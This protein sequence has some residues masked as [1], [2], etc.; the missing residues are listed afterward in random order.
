MMVFLRK[1]TRKQRRQ[2]N[3]ILISLGVGLLFTL[4]AIF[5]RPFVSFEWRLEDMLFL[6]T[7]PSSNIVI[8]AIDDESL[9]EHGRWSEWPRSLHAQAINNLAEAGAMV[10]GY[11][12]LFADESSDDP[13]LAQ[14][15]ADA[16]NVV[17]AV[18]GD[19]PVSS[20][21]EVTFQN[22][23]L[24]TSTLEDASAAEGHGNV[25]PDGDG[26]MRRIP[27]VIKDAE[28][29]SYPAL[30]VA[31]LY[32]HFSKTLPSDY[33]TQ[34]GVI[35]LLDRNIPVDSTS[36][37]RI[38]YVGAPGS[39]SQLSY[40]DVIEGNFNPELVKFKIVLV[41]M[42]ATGEPDSW[43]TPISAEKMYG[44][45]I[46]ANAMDTI[47]RQRFMMEG[48]WAI[49]LVTLL[50]FVG[51]T[52]VALPRLNL[53]WG[54]LLTGLIFFGYLVGVFLAFDNG[55]ILS[56]LYPLLVLPLLYVTVVLC[57]VVAEQS[58]RSQIRDLF[59]RYVSPQVAGKIMNLADSDELKLGGE[60]R[61]VTVLFADIRGF[62]TLSEKMVPQSIVTMLNTYLSVIIE[63]VLA[64]DGMVN[65]FA[66][67]SIMAVWN[68]PQD[69]PYHALLAVKAALE[70]EGEIEEMQ[71]RDAS[72]PRV[73]FGIGI[74]SG[75]SIAGNMGSEGR[76]EYTVIGD[77]VNIASRLCSGAPGGRIWI[78]PKTYEEVKDH[79]EVREIEP[80][81]FK[82]K[83]ERIPV[84]Q[85]VRLLPTHV[86]T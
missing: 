46:H 2:R 33:Q 41:G 36:S 39:F 40:A 61:E 47:L 55:Y 64:H 45:E 60:S 42:T 5:L 48:G 43:V 52:A 70:S 81:Q 79:V 76:T 62:T 69:Q 83:G 18:A 72:L 77:A 7:L 57:R 53:R 58:D 65:K 29:E 10:I 85:V 6:P 15:M 17:L 73:Q 12:V 34:D 38:N 78:G 37:M 30:V 66:G 80:Q 9:A 86:D 1:G 11:D 68:A 28:G 16:G 35:R 24:P 67:D 8:V 74:N 14:A 71:K 26:V 84:Y 44:V 59:G 75:D 19:R 32:T 50:F 13:M 49:T 3:H 31:S 54:G 27:L 51:V 21:P 25:V 23:L 4:I 63:K 56:I 82:G 22:V 20:F